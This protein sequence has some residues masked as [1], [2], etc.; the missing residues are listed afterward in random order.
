[1]KVHHVVLVLLFVVH[2]FYENN[3]FKQFEAYII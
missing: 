1:M 2:L 3:I